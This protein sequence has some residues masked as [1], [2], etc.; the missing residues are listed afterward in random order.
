MKSDTYKETM[1]AILER[2]PRYHEEAYAFVREG[3]DYTLKTL[4]PADH[5][6][7]HHVTGV[8][9]LEGIRQHAI[10][11]FGPIT[12]TVLEK[13]GVRTSLDIGEI[14][15][16]MVDARILGKTESDTREDFRD[17]Y[18][19]REAFLRPFLPRGAVLALEPSP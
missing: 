10:E 17:V 12:L 2:D 11:Q 5:P 15:F 8:Q 4:E 6:N 19:F 9:L 18:D 3:L 14:V 16:N 13:W 1:S 7:G